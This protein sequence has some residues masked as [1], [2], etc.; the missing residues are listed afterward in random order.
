MDA[1]PKKR[2]LYQWI[3]STVGGVIVSLLVLVALPAFG[4]VAAVSL[5]GVWWLVGLVANALVASTCEQYAIWCW[6]PV[7]GYIAAV[8]LLFG[9]GY[10]CTLV[11][12]IWKWV[13]EDEPEKDGAG[14]PQKPEAE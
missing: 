7:Q 13:F 12:Q 5:F 6:T 11:P 1:V 8:L 4:V 14:E 10:A 9:L 3:S 2:T